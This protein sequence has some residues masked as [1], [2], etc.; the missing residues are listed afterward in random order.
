M[1]SF[2]DEIT[3]LRLSMGLPVNNTTFHYTFKTNHD[4]LQA[5]EKIRKQI[6]YLRSDIEAI[7]RAALGSNLT[8]SNSRQG[9]P[10]QPPI[11]IPASTNAQ[12][13]Y[14]T[15]KSATNDISDSTKVSLEDP[16]WKVLPAALKKHRIKTEEWPNYAMFIAFG[17]PSEFLIF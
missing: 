5:D 17:P 1:R 14:P 11:T 6:P 13:S 16:T 7:G 8:T 10:T 4:Y 9:S 3:K 2:L 12:T 15:P